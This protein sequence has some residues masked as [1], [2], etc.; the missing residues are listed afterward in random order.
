M[1]IFKI[2]V[3][4]ALFLFLGLSGFVAG[5]YLWFT[6]QMV[7]PKDS[8]TSKIFIPPG[9]NT[10]QIATIL[11]QSKVIRSAFV[12]RLYIRLLAIDHKLRPGTYAFTP[13]DSVEEV[14][15]KLLKGT[16]KTV[17]V[18]I[19]EGITLAKTAQI[20]QEAGVCNSEDFLAAVSNPEL[21]GKIFSNWELIPAPEGLVF[22][23][24]YNFNRPSSAQKVA[25][26]MLSLTRHQIDEILPNDL[27]N[28]LSQYEACVLA[29]IVEREAVLHSERPLISSV[30]LNRLK[31]KMKL[32][33]CA[34]VQYALPEHKDRLLYEDL[35]IDSPYNT[36]KFTGLPPTPISNFGR[37]SLKAVADPEDTNYLYFVS[38]NRG[39]HNF[40]KSLSQHNKS[41]KL[42]LKNRNK[43]R[44]KIK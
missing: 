35:K 11:K 24:T 29:S 28:G 22:P 43:N 33:S 9:S 15:Y 1:K 18:T 17:S 6:E 12:F 34:T 3:Y 23:E 36:Y 2:M 32:E 8:A 42:Y 26:R 25:H 40:S 37:A 27:P 30:F 21:L 20:L 13:K 14:V 4:V 38:N 44:R 31:K 7:A 10:K 41:K 19:P 16:S 5:G 39:G